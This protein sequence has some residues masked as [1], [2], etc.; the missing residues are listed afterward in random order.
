[1]DG[2]VPPGFEAS[3]RVLRV[4]LPVVS[5]RVDDDVP[6]QLQ[7]AHLDLLAV[8]ASV[9]AFETGSVLVVLALLILL[10]MLLLLLLLLQLL[11]CKV[12]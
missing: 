11:S 3:R 2:N 1:M 10:L 9:V 6:S 12:L 7:G 5:F 8:T 4:R